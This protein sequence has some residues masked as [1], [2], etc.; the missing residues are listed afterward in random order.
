VGRRLRKPPNRG[1]PGVAGVAQRGRGR[2]VR[3]RLPPSAR[4]AGGAPSPG[5]V[6]SWPF[7]PLA[8]KRRTS[9]CAGSW[10]MDMVTDFCYDP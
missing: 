5:P 7:P 4:C 1:W 10:S 2:A 3:G 6:A 9:N 8:G